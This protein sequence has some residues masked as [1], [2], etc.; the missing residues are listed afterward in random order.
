M[1]RNICR[2]KSCESYVHGNGLCEMHYA[3]ARR[4]NPVGLAEKLRFYSAPPEWAFFRDQK[5]NARARGIEFILTFEEWMFVW[6]QSG[7]LLQRGLGKGKYCMAR[8]GDVGPY[9]IDN[10]KI[11]RF[12][13]NSSEGSLGQRPKSKAWRKVHSEAMRGHK[14][15]KERKHQ[16]SIRMQRWWDERRGIV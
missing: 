6:K 11:I 15:S 13:D 14:H 7:K 12:E 2:V 3:R 10:I 5:N 9:A 16:H 1:A 8:I 4:G